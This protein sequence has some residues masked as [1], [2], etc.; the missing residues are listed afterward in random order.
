MKNEVNIFY[1][2]NNYKSSN[3]F[4]LLTNET[5]SWDTINTLKNTIMAINI[6]IGR[7]I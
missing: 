7:G 6:V 1:R 4:N 3:N 2:N 5:I